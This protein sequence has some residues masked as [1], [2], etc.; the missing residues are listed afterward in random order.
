MSRNLLIKLS[1]T[2]LS[3]GMPNIDSL[4]PGFSAGDFAVLHGTSS[5]L[6]LTLLLS[7]RTQLPLRLGGLETSVIFV[8]GG[9]TFKPYKVSRIAQFYQL[10]PRQ[11]LD[12]V[13]ISRAFTAYQMTSVILEK[14]AETIDKHNSK[15]VIISDI[16]GL[17][18]DKDV[19]AEEAKEVFSQL[20][21]YLSRLARDKQVIII[22]TCLSHCHSKLSTLLHAVA[23]GRADVV[24]SVIPTKLGRVFALE[25]HPSLSVE[26]VKFLPDNHTMSQFMER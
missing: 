7:V 14:L 26:C 8:D 5:V 22:A 18:L 2:Q 3:L 13:H 16:A 15:L 12:R 24:A 25:K 9:N 19:P 1:Q 4:F 21:A 6:S 11:V 10:D 17:Y 20:T 23:C